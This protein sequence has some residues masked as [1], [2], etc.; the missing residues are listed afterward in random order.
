MNILHSL[1]W[2]E[3]IPT[4]DMGFNMVINIVGPLGHER[5]IVNCGKEK[6][7]MLVNAGITQVCKLASL[8]QN[9]EQ[10]KESIK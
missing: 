7:K 8:G 4:I 9:K 10:I 6:T 5:A 3:T 1:T 2:F